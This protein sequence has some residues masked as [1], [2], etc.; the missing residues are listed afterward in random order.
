MCG[1]LIPVVGLIGDR[2]EIRSDEV[3]GPTAT[4]LVAR[5]S[6]GGGASGGDEDAGLVSTPPGT[7][8]LGDEVASGQEWDDKWVVFSV[9]PHVC[10]GVLEFKGM[11]RNGASI[12]SGGSDSGIFALYKKADLA[13]RLGIAIPGEDEG[14]DPIAGFLPPLTGREYYPSLDEIDIVA[15]VLSTSRSGGFH[16]VA[17]WPDWLPEPDDV[18]LGVWG[19]SPDLREDDAL[20]LV[21]VDNCRPDSG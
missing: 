5:E 2:D 7:W 21:H 14:V 20:R 8:E 6:G 17:E 13:P 15:D 19:Y 1:L 10:D 9:R 11:A 12:S 18:V 3:A 4:A 16:L